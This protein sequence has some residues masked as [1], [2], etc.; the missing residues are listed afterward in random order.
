MTGLV[1]QPQPVFLNL[2]KFFVKRE[3]FSGTSCTCGGKLILRVR[4]NLLEMTGCHD[5][6]L[7]ILDCRFANGYMRRQIQKCEI[8][9]QLDRV[10][11][12]FV[13]ESRT[14]DAEKTALEMK[15]SWARCP[16]CDPGAGALRFEKCL[17]DS[18]SQSADGSQ[19][20]PAQQGDWLTRSP[21]SRPSLFA[22]FQE[23]GTHAPAAR[24]KSASANPPACPIFRPKK[25]CRR[26]PPR[27]F[28]ENRSSR[29]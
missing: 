27:S 10:T 21:G 11:P 18:T 3:N 17:A 16:A 1:F 24:A 25:A 26:S 23:A 7:S 5:F 9:L 22:C 15:R 28:P 14:L 6:G 29:R 4:Q 20:A 12:H 19:K 13:V 8:R 2:E